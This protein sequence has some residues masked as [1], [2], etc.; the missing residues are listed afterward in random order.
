MGQQ[1]SE[2]GDEARLTR[3]GVVGERALIEAEHCTHHAYQHC[4]DNWKKKNIYQ[5]DNLT[6]EDAEPP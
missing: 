3:K 4:H 1:T 5:Q 2:P 6:Q